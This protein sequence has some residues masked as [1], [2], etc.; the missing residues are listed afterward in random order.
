MDRQCNEDGT[1]DR[2]CT[3]APRTPGDVGL[4]RASERAQPAVVEIRGEVKSEKK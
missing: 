1:G 3:C 2:I 4:A